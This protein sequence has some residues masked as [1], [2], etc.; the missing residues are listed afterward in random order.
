MRDMPPP[1]YQR[2]A[3]GDHRTDGRA[4]PSAKREPAGSTGQR[5]PYRS[6]LMPSPRS[7]PKTPPPPTPRRRGA[8]SGSHALG[9]APEEVD[10][11]SQE[12][13]EPDQGV[14]EPPDVERLARERR[15]RH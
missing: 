5:G 14:H 7:H 12:D 3:P 10:R 13:A 9:V 1:I 6:S 15:P 8:E 2:R 11:A 4:T